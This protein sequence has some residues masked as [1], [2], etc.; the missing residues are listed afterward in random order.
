MGD[1]RLSGVESEYK[2]TRRVMDMVSRGYELVDMGFE[3]VSMERDIYSYGKTKIL[4]EGKESKKH[5]AVM[6][7]VEAQI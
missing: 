7:R 3:V 2:F 4:R 6:R 5:W 1:I